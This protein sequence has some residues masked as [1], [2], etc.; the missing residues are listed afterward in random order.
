VISAL[1]DQ[2]SRRHFTTKVACAVQKQRRGESSLPRGR[3][4]N[5]ARGTAGHK[6]NSEFTS[7]S[8]RDKARRLFRLAGPVSG[9][10]PLGQAN[11]YLFYSPSGLWLPAGGPQQPGLCETTPAATRQLALFAATPG[12]LASSPLHSNPRRRQWSP[13]PHE[14][15]QTRA[16]DLR[17]P[18]LLSPLAFALACFFPGPFPSSSCLPPFLTTTRHR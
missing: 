7:Q 14:T 5:L 9:S 13:H 2:Q 4:Q 18:V 10:C 15:P 1:F 17:L 16:R 3:S 11:R 12:A 6:K 8:S